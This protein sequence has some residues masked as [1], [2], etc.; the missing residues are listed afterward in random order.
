MFSSSSA[1]VQGSADCLQ[2]LE[3]LQQSANTGGASQAIFEQS[4]SLRQVQT[5]FPSSRFHLREV[6][7]SKASTRCLNP[8]RR[9]RVKY[10]AGT[11]L[12]WDLGIRY[13]LH[14]QGGAV[15]RPAFPSNA[16]HPPPTPAHTYPTQQLYFL[17]C[18]RGSTRRSR[19]SLGSCTMWAGCF[20]S[21]GSA[22]GSSRSSGVESQRSRYANH[23][24]HLLPHTSPHGAIAQAPQ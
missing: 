16:R 3:Q 4:M 24:P 2:Q 6:L 17:S 10:L 23:R 21:S 11:V 12:G 13:S 20:S 15:G 1:R 19:Q 18:H 9:G 22:N 5:A 7:Q 14:N 8:A